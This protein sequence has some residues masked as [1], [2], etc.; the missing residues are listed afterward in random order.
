MQFEL[1]ELVEII[2]RIPIIPIGILPIPRIILRILLTPIGI[3]PT[4]KIIGKSLPGQHSLAILFL[5]FLE[6]AN[7]SNW[8]YS[9]S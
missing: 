1:L 8:N 6:L 4:C 9:N 5:E 2:L 7:N 3:I